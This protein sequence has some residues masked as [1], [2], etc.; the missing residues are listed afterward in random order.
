M[1][2]ALWLCLLGLLPVAGGKAED[3]GASFRWSESAGGAA[4]LEKS[5]LGRGSRGG[6]GSGAPWRVRLVLF[7][8]LSSTS[9]LYDALRLFRTGQ[10]RKADRRG[11]GAAPAGKT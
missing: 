11:S 6:H 2:G 9:A 8:G 1:H 10:F 5:A 7:C 4:L 3:R